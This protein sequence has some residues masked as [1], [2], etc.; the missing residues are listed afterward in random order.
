MQQRGL[1]VAVLARRLAAEPV[2]G[3]VARGGDDPARRARG[4]PARRPALDRGDEGVL[5]RLL[6]EVDV[7]EDADQDG[8]RAAVFLAEDTFDLRR[9]GGH[10]AQPSV[11][12]WKGRT[13]TGRRDGAGGLGGPLERRVEVGG[14]DDPE[15][16]DVL[17]ALGERAVGGEHLAVL[18]RTTVAVP[19]GCSPPANTQAPAAFISSLK[20]STSVHDSRPG[21]LG[22]R[23]HAVDG[24]HDA[25]AGSA[26]SVVPPGGCVK[27]FTTLH[28]R[29]PPE[30]DSRV[31]G[32][33]YLVPATV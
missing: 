2:D 9:V 15:P 1:R 6:G 28:E 31:R 11:S 10:G 25:E 19:A 16:A 17:L 27:P 7:A 30:I 21:P 23:R 29:R 14:V 8:D 33:L 13:S 26:S 20:A 18:M 5:D 3:A 4:E 12:S 32:T 24:L 22:L